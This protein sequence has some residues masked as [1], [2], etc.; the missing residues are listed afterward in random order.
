MSLEVFLAT[1]VMISVSSFGWF[2]M[3]AVCSLT[4]KKLI[5]CEKEVV[6]ACW[7]VFLLGLVSLKFESCFG[8][9]FFP[10]QPG[11]DG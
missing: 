2:G 8:T 4:S 5:T 10:V 1:L 6:A 11:V 9:A 3:E 7:W